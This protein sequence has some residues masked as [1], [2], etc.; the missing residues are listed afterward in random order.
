MIRGTTADALGNISTEHEAFHQDLLS[1]A[2][3]ARNSGGIVIAQVKRLTRAGALDP[4][5]VR[6]PG[7]LVDYVV[8]CE[9]S[10][11]H[12]MTFAEEF[13]PAYT[14]EVRQPEQDFVALPLDVRKIIA[15]RAFLEPMFE[16][17]SS[18]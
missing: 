18:P 5:L 13:N 7:I 1:I 14:G 17:A 15:R 8:V 11:D 16:Q 3:A 9:R 12:W 10:E 2:Q 6:V 4:N